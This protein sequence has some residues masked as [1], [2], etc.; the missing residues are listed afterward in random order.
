M[1][2]IQNEM[3]SGCSQLA[4]III[5][6]GVTSIGAW[7]F[8]GCGLEGITFPSG[9]TEIKYGAFRDCKALTAITIPAN[10]TSIGHWAFDGCSSLETVTMKGDTPPTL[11]ASGSGNTAHFAGCKFVTENAKG[12][13]VPAGTANVYKTAWTDWAEYIAGDST[14]VTPTDE[15]RWQRRRKQWKMHWQ[16]SRY[17]TP[18]RRKSLRKR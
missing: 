12:I 3:F 8:K 1:E 9:V 6:D 2:S 14:P 16:T 7:A 15:E 17:P 4:G 11:A 18:P 10:V 5:P 13:K